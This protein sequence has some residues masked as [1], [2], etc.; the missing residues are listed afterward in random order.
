MSRENKKTKKHPGR[1]KKV[2]AII[3]AVIILFIAVCA[4]VSA[5]GVRSNIN[6]SKFFPAVNDELNFENISNGVWNIYTD[7]ELKVLQLTDIHLGGGFM[8]IKK[9]SMSLNAVAA[10]VSAEKPDFIVV[11]G[12]IAY[13]VFFQAG[14]FNNKYGARMF[15]ELMETLGVYWTVTFG[16][17][18]TEAYSFYTREEICDF[19]TS[20]AYPHCLLQ[21][22]PDDVDGCGNQIFNIVNSDGIITRSLLLFD[23]HSY[24]D[25]DIFGIFWKYDNIHDNQIKWYS[26]TIKSLAASNTEKCQSEELKAKYEGLCKSVPTS[27]FMHIPLTEYNDAI[28]EYIDNDFKSTEDAVYNYGTAAE[29]VCC[30]IHEDDLFET[31]LECNSTDTVFSGHDHVNNI[32]ITY[33]GI[34]LVYSPSVDYLAYIG[35]YK[36]GSQRGCTVLKYAP[37]GSI[38][39]EPENYYQDKYT[40]YYEK[41]DVTMQEE[42][43]FVPE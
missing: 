2:I 14:T 25:G 19:Y 43:M 41:E 35:I 26:D 29:R 17:H 1:T 6:K 15:A 8:S 32:S 11:T 7:K 9:D 5:V 18:D 10:M 21:P 20:G 4:T 33:K 3:L 40:S 34:D 30:G 27:V 37:D 13:P 12:D 42:I 36:L 31:M 24:V 39:Y 38:T 23:S 22:G 16:N 28:Q